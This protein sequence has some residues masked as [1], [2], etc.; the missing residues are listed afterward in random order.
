M[1]SLAGIPLM[2]IKKNQKGKQKDDHTRAAVLAALLAGQR[3]SEVASE[4]KL[5]H[6]TVSRWKKSLSPDKLDE[7]GRKKEEDFNGLIGAYLKETLTT[8]RAQTKFFRNETWLKKQTATELAVLHGVQAD[9]AF[10]LLEAIERAA[11]TKDGA[12]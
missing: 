2:A 4:F 10:S 6:S 5:P 1:S 3:V 8:L 9:K 7:V 12:A 11:A